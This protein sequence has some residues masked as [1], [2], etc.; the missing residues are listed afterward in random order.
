MTEPPWPVDTEPLMQI[1]IRAGDLVR[2]TGSSLYYRV[3]AVEGHLAEL[4]SIARSTSHQSAFA[5]LSMLERL[6]VDP[7]DLDRAAAKT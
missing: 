4:L 5:S 1:N 7:R 3:M 2:L 6:N